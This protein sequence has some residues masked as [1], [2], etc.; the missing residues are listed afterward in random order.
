M[1]TVTK[2]KI[3]NMLKFKLGLSTIICEEL[4]EQIFNNIK[5]IASDQKLTLV[6]FGKFYTNLKKPRVGINFKTK[7]AIVISERKVM[8]FIPSQKLKLLINKNAG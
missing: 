3:A 7:E 5:E 2:E 1:S 4:V 6:N 8:R